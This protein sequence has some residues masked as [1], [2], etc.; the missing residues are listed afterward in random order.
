MTK[1]TY[2]KDEQDKMM[3]KG[4][5]YKTLREARAV[6]KQYECKSTVYPYCFA[7]ENEYEAVRALDLYTGNFIGYTV[8]H[9]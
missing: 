7:G 9:K 3:A 2:N 1:R 4:T 5:L 8:E 6:V